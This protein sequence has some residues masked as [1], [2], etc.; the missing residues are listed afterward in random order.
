MAEL[1]DEDPE[2][3]KLVDFIEKHIICKPLE[4]SLRMELNNWYPEKEERCPT[5][6][7]RV[8]SVRLGK[9]IKTRETV[10]MICQTCGRNYLEE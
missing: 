8:W 10:D 1:P 7:G 3:V 6:Q 2:F 4:E 5:C 9:W